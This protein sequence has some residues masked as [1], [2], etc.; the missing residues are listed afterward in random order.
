MA[1]EQQVSN[2]LPPPVAANLIVKPNTSPASRLASTASPA[3]NF[4]LSG[5]HIASSRASQACL[6]TS[7]ATTTACV[8]T[9]NNLND[10]YQAPPTAN[11]P[12][13]A[14]PHNPKS[15]SGATYLPFN[16]TLSTV[17]MS[18]AHHTPGQADSRL[19]PH[20]TT[21]TSLKR[22]ADVS[23]DT[24]IME[25]LKRIK[26]M[27][28]VSTTEPQEPNNRSLLPTQPLALI[29]QELPISGSL[30]TRTNV[31]KR[32]VGGRPKAT[33]TK[34]KKHVGPTRLRKNKPVAADVHMDIWELILPY[35]P[36]R[37]LFTARNVSKL[38]RER[39]AYSSLW[40]KCRIRNYGTEMPDALSGM[41]EWDYAN[42]L[43][44][45][46]CMGC[47]NK[48]TRKTYWAF[49]KRWCAKCLEKNTILVRTPSL[50]LHYSGETSAYAAHRRARRTTS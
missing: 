50:A 30:Q 28:P 42:L 43:E 1:A 8:R 2:G 23:P 31:V 29:V 44:G 24:P 12:S 22:R 3:S 4:P 20:A 21:L 45:L 9:F 33:L 7:Q 14:N 15:T 5:A 10:F 34:Q 13:L 37:F 17:T 16:N 25:T 38:F 46:G 19:D 32:N 41:K 35:C 36:L 6:E 40:K 39:L 47:T 11:S 26:A 48:K 18:T 27:D 49:Q